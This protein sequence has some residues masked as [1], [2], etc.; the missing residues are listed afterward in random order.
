MVWNIVILFRKMESCSSESLTNILVWNLISCG[1]NRWLR[2]LWK[3]SFISPASITN[4]L[5]GVFQFHWILL[6]LN[7]DLKFLLLYCLKKWNTVSQNHL[8]IFSSEILIPKLIW[9]TA[10]RWLKVL[11]KRSL[12]SPSSGRKG[13]TVQNLIF[14]IFQ[15]NGLLD[16]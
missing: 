14:L 8:L 9:L 1:G 2:F 7:C 5:I 13:L 3:K 10:S 4:I 12:I 6:V 15:S 16:S 11:W